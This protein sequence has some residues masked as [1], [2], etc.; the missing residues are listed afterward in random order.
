MPVSTPLACTSGT[1][2][3]VVAFAFL[4]IGRGA[5]LIE[6]K[7]AS[8][9]AAFGLD[10]KDPSAGFVLKRRLALRHRD[11]QDSWTW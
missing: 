1:A 3:V 2:A 8:L 7:G 6:V 10:M 9:S 5:R 11:K 4:A